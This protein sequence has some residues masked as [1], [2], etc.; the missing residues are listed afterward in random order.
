MYTNAEEVFQSALDLSDELGR[1]G[2]IAEAQEIREV[3][4]AFW[5]SSTEALGE[6]RAALGKINGDAFPQDIHDKITELQNACTK[7]MRL[8]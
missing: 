5:T 6:L 3:V 1:K 4:R 2:V 8:S 7:L